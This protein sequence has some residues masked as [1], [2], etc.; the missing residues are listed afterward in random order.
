MSSFGLAFLNTFSPPSLTRHSNNTER[1]NGCFHSAAAKRLQHNNSIRCRGS[2]TDFDLYELLGIDSSSDQSEI[3]AAYRGLQKRCHPDIAGPT[4]HD[5]AIILNEAY[6]VLSDPS[7]RSVYDK[8]QAKMAEFR[9]YTGKPIYSSWHG[10]SEE[11]RAVFVD[12]VKCVGCLKCALFAENTFAI[13]SVYGRA[14]VVAQWADPEPKIFDAI[15]TCPVD[16]ISIVEKTNLAALE[17]LMS[18]QPRGNVRMTG[19]NNVG[20]RVANVFVD[21]HKFQRLF[22]EQQEKTS[23]QDSQSSDFRREARDAAM[24][25][26]RSISNWW[27]WRTPKTGTHTMRDRRYLTH[28]P[29]KR[30][31]RQPD[32]ERLREAAA[33]LKE[34]ERQRP[35]SHSRGDDDEYWTPQLVLPPPLQTVP[36]IDDPTPESPV[37]GVKMEDEM[38]AN[39]VVVDGGFESTLDSRIPMATAM[40]SMAVVGFGSGGGGGGGLEEHVGGSMAVEIIN[41]SWLQVLQAGMVW[42]VVGLVVAGMIGVIGGRRRI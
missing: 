7:S 40:V 28:V 32:V 10:S 16:C 31:A 15:Q 13:E 22:K 30:T 24:Q 34:M 2:I 38:A 23:K 4:G 17:F 27:Y 8:E 14:R 36:K 6:L 33:K 29:R 25:G 11:N 42:Y 37:T 41:S 3:K 35:V 18:K 20:T 5:M 12:E 21:V 26:I 1:L 19:G 9:G 39:R